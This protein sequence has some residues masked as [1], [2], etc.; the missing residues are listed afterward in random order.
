MF[1]ISV[2]VG[3]KIALLCER[4]F[5]KI[6]IMPYS[7]VLY[8]VAFLFLTEYYFLNFLSCPYWTFTQ[9]SYQVSCASFREGNQT[10]FLNI[11]HTDSCLGN[12]S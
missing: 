2:F 10:L 4:M 8:P 7:T 1:C 11:T 6:R 9:A 12:T 3:L 5:S